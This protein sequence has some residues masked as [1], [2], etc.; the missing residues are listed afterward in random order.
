MS[1]P[2]FFL[3]PTCIMY[4]SSNENPY[5]RTRTKGKKLITQGRL[6]SDK[7]WCNAFTCDLWAIIFGN[8]STIRVKWPY[9]CFTYSLK[10][11]THSKCFISYYYHLSTDPSHGHVLAYNWE[12]LFFFLK[13]LVIKTNNIFCSTTC[14]P[15]PL[16]SFL[17]KENLELKTLMSNLLSDSCLYMWY[18]CGV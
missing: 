4:L 11:V 18:V 8:F 6:I 1:L 7:Q 9:Y 14:R 16:F 10:T 3:F 17:R 5:T 15:C 13:L 2:A 12:V